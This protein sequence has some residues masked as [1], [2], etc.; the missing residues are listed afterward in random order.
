MVRKHQFLKLILNNI[1][2]LAV[3][4]KRT[5]SVLM[6]APYFLPVTDG[7]HFAAGANAGC[8]C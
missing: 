5:N 2:G 4:V 6:A 1:F 8:P 3:N 7:L